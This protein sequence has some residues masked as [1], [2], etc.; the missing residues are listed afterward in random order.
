M[1]GTAETG[2]P[3]FDKIYRLEVTV[4]PTNRAA[5]AASRIPTSS[6]APRKRKYFAA[7]MRFKDSTTPVS[8]FSSG[9]LD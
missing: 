9:P 1:T 7:Q 4:I 8:L 2:S 3:E 5:A 6:I